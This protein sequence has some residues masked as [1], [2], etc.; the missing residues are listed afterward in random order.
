MKELF[1]V[2]I[3]VCATSLICTLVTTFVT[4]GSTKKIVNLVLGAFIICCMINPVKNAVSSFD[5]DISQY[6]TA[7]NITASSD[8]AYSNM[9]VNRTRENLELAAADLL[10]Q[11]NIEVESCKFILATEGGERII[12]SSASIYINKENAGCTNEISEL[13]RTNFGVEPEIIM[14]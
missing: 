6:E 13:I 11:N 2:A 14:E 7:E 3:V 1:N 4:D 9:I 10:M 8:E 5:I 12:I